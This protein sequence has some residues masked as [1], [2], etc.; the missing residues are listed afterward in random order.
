[1]ADME[2]IEATV[3]EDYSFSG[4]PFCLGYCNEFTSLY[5]SGCSRVERLGFESHSLAA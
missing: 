3:G 5:D 1:M 4:L 2:Y